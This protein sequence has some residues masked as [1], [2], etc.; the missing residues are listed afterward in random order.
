MPRQQTSLI[1][2]DAKGGRARPLMRNH[3]IKIY[4]ETA[5]P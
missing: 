1:I 5:T 2:F 3:W 4:P